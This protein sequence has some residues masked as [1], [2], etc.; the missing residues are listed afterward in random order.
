KQQSPKLKPKIVEIP[1]KTEQI[2]K[3]VNLESNRKTLSLI[4]TFKLHTQK[5][6]CMAISLE[7]KYLFTGGS[8]KF[9]NIIN[10][11]D[12]KRELNFEPFN[13]QITDIKVKETRTEIYICV[14]S[15]EKELK[16]FKYKISESAEENRLECISLLNGHKGGILSIDFAEDG[17]F[18]VDIDG[19]IRKWNMKGEILKTV[20]TGDGVKSICYFGKNSLI[21]SDRNKVYLMDFY[22]NEIIRELVKESATTIKRCPGGYLMCLRNQV[23]V[24][25]ENLNRINTL[26]SAG[27]KP[28]SACLLMDNSVLVGCY[29]NIFQH[30]IGSVIS[31]KA[32]D[33]MVTCLDSIVI[34]NKCYVVS[35]SQ[36]GECKIWG[37][38]MRETNDDNNEYKFLES[39]K[40]S[41][42]QMLEGAT[43][44]CCDKYYSNYNSVNK[45]SRHRNKSRRSITP[46]GYWDLYMD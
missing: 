21:V 38:G 11:R 19:E 13:K 20:P 36:S 31:I 22:K 3:E 27:D 40:N 4:N 44:P 41:E 6:T 34:F 15:L 28:Q 25:D 16:L 23:A 37:Y 9:L 17:V 1:E 26:P 24:F 30:G 29:Q 45:S 5:I 2:P 33:N 46:P 32:H 12:M 14:S 10:L 39:L 7:S 42:R 35:C 43:C 18:S 8:D